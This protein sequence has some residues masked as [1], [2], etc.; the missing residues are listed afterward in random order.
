MRFAMPAKPSL[1]KYR[2]WRPYT[3]GR[4]DRLAVH[5]ADSNTVSTVRRDARFVAGLL[6]NTK[7]LPSLAA[8][9]SFTFTLA[10]SR[11][12]TVPGHT[13]LPSGSSLKMSSGGVMWPGIGAHRPHRCPSQR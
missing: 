3:D 5:L 10:V 4:T 9:I 12:L 7:L 13:T 1:T 2:E 6:M 11:S 8:A